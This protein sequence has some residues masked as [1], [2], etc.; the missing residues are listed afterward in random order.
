MWRWQLRTF[1]TGRTGT[2]EL[3]GRDFGDDLRDGSCTVDLILPCTQCLVSRTIPRRS[4]S[5][6]TFEIIFR[7]L[8]ASDPAAEPIRCS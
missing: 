8:R 7:P 1:L 6:V 2:C 5:C 3:R 4:S